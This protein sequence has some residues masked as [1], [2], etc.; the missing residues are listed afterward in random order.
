M[1]TKQS[2]Y[3]IG[4]D[5]HKGVKTAVFMRCD[6]G[7][8]TVMD[9]IHIDKSPICSDYDSECEDVKDKTK[10]WLY[11]CSKGLCPYLQ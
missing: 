8:F 6:K 9:V 2:Q 4:I 10:C 5:N 11:D 7:V 3:M 1:K